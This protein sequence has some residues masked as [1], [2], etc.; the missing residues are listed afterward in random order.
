MAFDSVVHPKLIHQLQTFGINGRLL[1]WIT[2]FLHGRLQCVV[3]ENRYSFLSKVISGVPQGSVLGPM[4]FVLLIDDISN[5]TVN[6]VLTKLY[7]DDLISLLLLLLFL[8]E[9]HNTNR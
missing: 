9:V 8:H 6:G 2:A 4:L 5:I 7:A 1:K 3:V